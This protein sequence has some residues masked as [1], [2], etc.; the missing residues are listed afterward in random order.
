MLGELWWE[1]GEMV[2]QSRDRHGGG[3]GYPLYYAH[4]C[5]SPRRTIPRPGRRIMQ[6]KDEWRV[7]IMD[8]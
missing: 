4:I 7:Q 8:A 6:I 2:S 3:G 5:C 1:K